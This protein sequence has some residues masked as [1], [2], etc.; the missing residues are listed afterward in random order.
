M[1]INP[2]KL[3]RMMRSK[4]IKAN[5]VEAVEVIIRTP[6]GDIVI[7]DPEVVEVEVQGMKFFQVSGRVKKA[8]AFP[9]EDVKLVMETANVDRERAIRALEAAKGKPADAILLIMEGKV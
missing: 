5:P 6:E 9:E 4:G 7:A 3:E 1:R 8:G 2:R